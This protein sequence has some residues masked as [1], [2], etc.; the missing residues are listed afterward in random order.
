MLE[1]CV[2][3]IFSPEGF[4]SI[5]WKDAERQRA[6]PAE[7]MKLTAPELLHLRVIDDVIPEPEGGAH[8]APAIAHTGR[9]TGI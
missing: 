8:L 9:W 7:L 1:N 5:L 2:Y 3:A 4:A 6:R